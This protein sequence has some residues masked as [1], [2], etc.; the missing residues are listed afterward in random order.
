MVML[1]PLGPYEQGHDL[2]V[3]RAQ[4]WKKPKSLTSKSHHTGPTL[5]T[6]ELLCDRERNTILSCLGATI[7]SAESTPN[8]Y[9]TNQV[10]PS[11]PTT[12]RS[13]SPAPGT[14]QALIPHSS[15]LLEAPAG[16]PA[17]ILN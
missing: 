12:L 1:S 3:V 4:R 10:Q 2:E 6:P 17:R 13:L 9:R 16:Y 11:F 15:Y 5:F 7:L 14:F 8:Q